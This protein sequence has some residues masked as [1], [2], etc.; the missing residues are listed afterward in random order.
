MRALRAA[1][2]CLVV[3]AV[4][5]VRMA[6][7]ARAAPPADAAAAAADDSAA[8]VPWFCHDL[9]CPRF[10]I[11]K[12]LTDLGIELRRYP[13][14]KWAST[15]IEGSSY[16]KAVATGFW[17]LFKYISGN[18][19]D[20]AKVE[21]AAPVTVKVLAG[22]GPACKDTFTVSFFVPFAH[23]SNPPKPSDESVFIESR[24]AADVYVASFGGWA[25]GSTYLDHA[26]DTAKALEGEGIETAGGFFWTA[27]YD[28][29]FRLT[30]RHNE[31]W[32]PAAA[33]SD[34]AAE[35][36]PPAAADAPAVAAS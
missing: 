8:A 14:A 23:Q 18:N 21:M 26:A 22:Q 24:P 33:P 30:S 5:T 15:K 6:D 1:L 29:P 27:G 34:A 36:E 9:D 31:V 35:S 3:L 17:R 20:G 10:S 28:S 4:C 25:R 16:D 12:N 11:K 13:A 2:G 32:I 7:A 19:A